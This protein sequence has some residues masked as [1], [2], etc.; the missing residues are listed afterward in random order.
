[1]FDEKFDPVD[2]LDTNERTRRKYVAAAL[3][4]WLVYT[5]YVHCHYP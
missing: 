4:D 1:M 5:K 3:L 2:V